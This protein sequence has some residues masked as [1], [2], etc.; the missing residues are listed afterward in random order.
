[1]MMN[2]KTNCFGMSWVDK[3]VFGSIF[4]GEVSLGVLSYM[5]TGAGI[6]V[7]CFCCC[8]TWWNRV[9]IGWFFVVVVAYHI[10][11]YHIP[12]PRN[13]FSGILG[14]VKQYRELLVAGEL[15]NP[16]RKTNR[17]MAR[18]ACTH[19]CL[20][21]GY[22]LNSPVMLYFR[23]PLTFPFHWG[24]PNF[25]FQSQK[26]NGRE[27]LKAQC[28]HLYIYIYNINKQYD[29]QWVFGTTLFSEKAICLA[30]K[31]EMS[32]APRSCSLPHS[33]NIQV[34]ILI[35]LTTPNSWRGGDCKIIIFHEAGS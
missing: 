9:N 6:N 35:S 3:T 11:S 30:L 7:G 21:I 4:E 22:P 23:W 8:C 31:H 34:A 24:I 20:K 19:M 17:R 16:F 2:P 10:I 18:K 32:T 25:H 28:F 1:M 27:D 12:I 14:E 33:G 13:C 26:N 5:F 15:K 29:K